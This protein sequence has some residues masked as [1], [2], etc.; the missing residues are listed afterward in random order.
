M[1]LTCFWESNQILF[2]DGH[3]WGLLSCKL[4]LGGIKKG[5]SYWQLVSGGK[6]DFAWYGKGSLLAFIGEGKEVEALCDFLVEL[7]GRRGSQLSGISWLFV[8]F[9]GVFVHKKLEP[10]SLSL[11]FRWL[12]K[13]EEISALQSSLEIL[14]S[15]KVGSYEDSKL[16]TL[17][18]SGLF[19]M[20][21]LT[22]HLSSGCPMQK[23]L[24]W[25]IW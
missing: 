22:C 1:D 17:G 18:A 19:S 9:S 5:S 16:W 23:D 6:G 3:L 2:V 21:S 14:A 13:H 20:K 12:L 10:P 8:V 24:F 7:L 25:S 11:I 15:S 4:H